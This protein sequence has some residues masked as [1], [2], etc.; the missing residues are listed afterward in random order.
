MKNSGII[1]IIILFII[2]Y[3]I[4]AIGVVGAIIGLAAGLFY[5]IKWMIKTIHENRLKSINKTSF[6]EYLVQ[7]YG[8]IDTNTDDEKIDYK[9]RSAL[10]Q[11]ISL[12]DVNSQLNHGFSIFKSSYKNAVNN[13]SIWYN[14]D[15]LQGISCDSN[16]L[17]R[18]TLSFSD[19]GFLGVIGSG[20]HP[21]LLKAKN[22][23][24]YFYPHFVI[25]EVNCEYR[26]I[27][28]NALSI[29]NIDSIYV[30]EQ[31]GKIIR[32]AS[33]VFYNY[34]HQRVD[35]G[36]DRRY[37]NNPSTPV[38]CHTICR[39]LFGVEYQIISS[40]NDSVD[41]L[42]RGLREYQKVLLA[43]P[44]QCKNKSETLLADS[45]QAAFVSDKDVSEK[46]YA[47]LFKKIID[48]R[49]KGILNERLFLSLLADYKVFKEKRFLRPFIET[50]TDEGYWTE[51][52]EGNP[53]VDTLN[54]IKKKF[55]TIHQYPEHEVTEAISY[56]GYG[57]GIIV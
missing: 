39:L 12:Q 13:S 17:S 33:P 20:E 31:S 6:Y 41:L 2:G 52:T 11:I 23:S 5:V 45:K 47:Y 18:Y 30:S 4:M 25:T 40:T 43:H 57:L 9:L 24:F 28:Y 56:I 37:K 15:L 36:P 8:L 35:G 3:A 42:R 19:K 53:S 46:N 29:K 1:G 48:G 34:L 21:F 14:I 50:M 51:L 32:G 27:E 55:I 7:H 38:Y 16:S 22:H 49:G 26:I 44:I 54:R 10:T